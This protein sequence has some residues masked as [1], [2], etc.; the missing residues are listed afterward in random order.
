MFTFVKNILYRPNKKNHKEN[1]LEDNALTILVNSKEPYLHISITNT[2]SD[3]IENFA[4][5]LYE[6]NSGLYAPSIMSILTQ[7]S[8]RDK[9]IA[10][11]VSGVISRWSFLIESNQNKSTEPLI[12]PTGF[13]R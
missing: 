9:N 8:S 5:M 1:P 2:N 6:L 4:K 3:Q 12:K 10:E 7:L 13:I 11:F